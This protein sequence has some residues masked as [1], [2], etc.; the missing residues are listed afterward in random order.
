MTAGRAMENV[1]AAVDRGLAPSRCPEQEARDLWQQLDDVERFRMKR[2]LEIGSEEELVALVNR[3]TQ[4]ERVRR[5]ASDVAFVGTF[6]TGRL[7][8]HHDGLRMFDE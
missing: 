7:A 2:E 1:M 6:N 3:V 5:A 4:E 8:R